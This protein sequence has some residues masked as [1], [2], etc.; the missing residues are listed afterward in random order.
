MIKVEKS[1][2]YCIIMAGGTGIRFWP[3]ASAEHPKQFIDVMG[4]GETML[5]STFHRMERICPREN[6]IIVSSRNDCETVHS[7]IEGL[8]EYQVLCEP[9][10]RGTAPCIAYAASVIGERCPDANIIVT[11]S[12]HAIFGIEK[13][14]DNIAQA[15][16]SASNHDWIITV[17]VK[18]TNPNTKYGYIQYT[19]EPSQSGIANLHKVVTFT[20]KPPLEM[21]RKF[22][23][24][25]EF[26]WNAGILVWRHKILKESFQ[27]FLPGVASIFFGNQETDQKGIGSRSSYDEI[28]RAYSICESISTDI[29][30]LEKA[31]NV[32]VMEASFGWSDVETWD[33]LYET[34][35]KDADGNVIIGRNVFTYDVHNTV[36]HLP[37]TGRT[38]VLQGL[39][40]YIVAS[41]GDTL[42][43]C[44]RDHEDHIVKYR[45]DVAF[46]RL[47]NASENDNNK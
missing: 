5:Q 30:I 39:D 36:I 35:N 28:E 47:R 27:R 32:H 10:R 38:V 3:M 34:C 7:Q 25:G 33:S 21:A 2:N 24:S 15:I 17:G 31:E 19:E 29:G 14:V 18:P 6:I 11:P 23:M 20:E 40:G 4:S 42:M 22:I 43:V 12:D 37:D 41:D 1:N 45:S 13:Y 8:S 16:E 26:M 44:R 46:D 9:I